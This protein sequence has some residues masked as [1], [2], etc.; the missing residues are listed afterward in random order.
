MPHN[1]VPFAKK[2]IRYMKKSIKIFIAQL[3]F[4]FFITGALAAL[5]KSEP[6]EDI[7][8]YAQALYQAQ[9]LEQA[10]TEFKRYIF[11]QD[12]AQE[13]GNFVTQSF[14]TL[15]NI[16]EKQERWSLAALTIQKAIN[17]I[18]QNGNE[19]AS[20]DTSA[21]T[22]ALRIQH[23]KY[24]YKSYQNSKKYLSDDL[25]IFSYM[26][27]PDISDTV[28]QCAYS[29]AISNAVT[30]G[31]I[32]YA[33]KT[34]EEAEK[35]FPQS[36]TEQQRQVVNAGFM[37]LASFK[38]KNQKLAGYLSF[39]PGLGQ[40]YAANYKDS[41]NAFLLNGSIIAVSVYSI[42]TLDF[43][44]FSLLEFDPLI[45]FMKGNIYNAQKDAYNYNLKKQK[46]FAELILECLEPE[47]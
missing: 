17:S 28:K 25:F 21:L 32:E 2:Q 5:Q 19:E 31:R 45:R 46:E 42:C 36:L 16:Y 37:K 12:Y 23:I 35:L 34:Y 3:C 13:Q 20:A 47:Q 18:E 40:L 7:Y 29:A 26:K 39:I 4:L 14:C 1:S 43:W 15:A 41:L 33:Q 38:P 6:Y 22:D 44:T 27:L 11:M 24:L 8:N 30:N 10:E 9:A